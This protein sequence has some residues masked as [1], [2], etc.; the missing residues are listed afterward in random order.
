MFPYHWANTLKCKSLALDL[1]FRILHRDT[2]FETK[3]SPCRV[4]PNVCSKSV[5]VAR[6]QR[7]PDRCLM[8]H[9]ALWDFQSVAVSVGA[10]S[11]RRLHLT[12]H[13][14]RCDSDTVVACLSFCHCRQMPRSWP[15]G[16][17]GFEGIRSQRDHKAIWQCVY[18]AFHIPIFNSHSFMIQLV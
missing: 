3:Q 5:C 12:Q 8:T 4:F 2:H 17:Q 1:N 9:L 16:R 14:S 15:L 13:L 6:S 18:C 7:S 10:G 11:P